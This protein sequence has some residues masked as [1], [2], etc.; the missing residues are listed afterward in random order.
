MTNDV[1]EIAQ[2]LYGYSTGA[3]AKGDFGAALMMLE[4]I[5]I[6]A[7]ELSALRVTELGALLHA[8]PTLPLQRYAHVTVHAPSRFAAEDEGNVAD[9]LA[10]VA[11]LVH[12]FIVHAEAIVDPAPWRA[13][14]SKVFVENA[15]ARKRTGRTLE[16][17]SRVMDRLPDANVCLDLAHAHQV[18]PT[19]LEAHRFTRAFADR[20][21]QIHLSQLD[22]A[23]RHQAL[24]FGIVAELRRLAPRLP[25]TTV[26]LEAP[27][28]PHLIGR[29]L[30]LARACFD[31]PEAMP[32]Y[33]A[34]S[35]AMSA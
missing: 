30:E 23:C 7:I 13:L 1:T 4:P 15:D 20:I 26:I 27:V 33:E 21:K 31:G 16:E 24:S 28:A 32:T 6:A 35:V 18:D 12:G 19:L 8:L 25:Q 2:R 14:G 3:L 10:R 29:Q 17:F 11:G 9:A 5:D 22:H 34:Y